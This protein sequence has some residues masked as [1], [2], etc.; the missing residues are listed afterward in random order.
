MTQNRN[1]NYILPLLLLLTACSKFGTLNTDPTKSSSMNPKNQLIYAQLWFSGDLSTQER[2]NS[3]VLLPL[4]QQFGAVYYARVGGMYVK[5]ATRMWVMWENSY[6]ND[7]VNIVDAAE[8]TKDVATQS[9]LNA[10]CRIMKV[11]TFARL[12]DLYGDIPYSQAGTAYYSQIKRPVYDKQ[13][14]IYND[15]LAELKAAAAQLDATKDKVP[16]EVFFKGDINAWKKFANSLRIRLAL[17]IAKRNPDKAKTEITEAYSGGVMTS[18]AD[19]CMTKHLDIQSTYSDV[20]GNAV[21]VAINQQSGMPKII[22]TFLNLLKNTND[23]RLNYIPRCYKQNNPMKP[24][25]REDITEQV[26]VTTVG[27][28]GSNPGRYVYDDWVGPVTIKLAN[29]TNYSAVNGDL[30]CELNNCFI[31]NNAPFL[32]LTYAEV[33]LLLADASIRLGITLGDDAATH[34]RKG[35]EAAMK[36]LSLYPNG[37]VVPDTAIAR[38]LTEN[39]LAAGTELKQINSQLYIALMLNGPETF[40]NWRRS[41]YPELKATPTN[42]S[43]STTI[44]RRFQYPLSEKEQ[45]AVNVQAAVERIG[46]DDWTRRVWWDKE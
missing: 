34:Y 5:D 28:T 41:G 16:E 20:R 35:I 17:R 15:F 3:I 44:P 21:S 18:N 19:I 38:F 31:R 13:E 24:F 23:P 39:P 1:Y 14:D 11:Y 9:N 4:V 27:L 6:P 40:A 43:T 36:Q 32:H 22:S 7:V 2:T 29:G 26:K 42:E 25:E 46:E 30:K 33:E 37:P 8:R 45:N 10:M 12:T